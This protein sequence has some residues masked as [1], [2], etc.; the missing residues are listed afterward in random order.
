MVGCCR[1]PR[2]KTNGLVRS[3]CNSPILM[4]VVT[5]VNTSFAGRQGRF[6][7]PRYS[8]RQSLGAPSFP[9]LR[10]AV[11]KAEIAYTVRIGPNPPHL[12]YRVQP[13]SRHMRRRG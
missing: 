2:D 11:P 7:A 6:G 4:G 8:V 5:N 1:R 10:S 3:P 12:F 9:A 13:G